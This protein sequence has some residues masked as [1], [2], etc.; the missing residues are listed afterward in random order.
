MWRA[1]SWTTA[2]SAVAMVELVARG[3]LSDTGFV[4][5][6]DVR[7]DDLLD[8]RSGRLFEAHGK[9]DA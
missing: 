2:A 1:I 5:Q 7:L 8:T 4:R 6:E 3:T 9:V